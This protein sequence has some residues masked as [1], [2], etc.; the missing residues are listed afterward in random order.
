MRLERARRRR[1][2][3]WI[4]VSGPSGFEMAVVVEETCAPQHTRMSGSVRSE[5]HGSKFVS[6]SASVSTKPT[7]VIHD[8]SPATVT[9]RLSAM[10]SKHSSEDPK[11]LSVTG[12]TMPGGVL[13]CFFLWCAILCAVGLCHT[14]AVSSL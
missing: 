3:Q 10:C 4:S 7:S 8:E 12:G 6:A 9:P 2:T 5:K 14:T 1:C 13:C 11:I